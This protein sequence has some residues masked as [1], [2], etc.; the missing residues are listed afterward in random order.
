MIDWS[1]TTVDDLDLDRTT[2]GL[3]DVYYCYGAA[4]NFI[5]V[6]ETQLINMLLMVHRQE[7]PSITRSEYFRFKAKLYEKETLGRLIERVGKKVQVPRQ[8]SGNLEVILE[9]RNMLAHH[10]FRQHFDKLETPEGRRDWVLE[11]AR[12]VDLIEDT[13]AGL[14]ALM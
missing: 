8:I 6:L 1:C 9:K 2:F 5:Q 12:F 11:L 10:F 4:I 3:E 7:N 14:E 13:D